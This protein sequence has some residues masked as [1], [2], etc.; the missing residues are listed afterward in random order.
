MIAPS[1]TEE[2]LQL[3]LNNRIRCFLMDF[4]GIKKTEKGFT[5]DMAGK[6]AY[7]FPY[8][9]I[10]WDTLMI[11]GHSEMYYRK[12]SKENNWRSCIEFR[13]PQSGTISVKDYKRYFSLILASVDD[14]PPDMGAYFES[15]PEDL[16]IPIVVPIIDMEHSLVDED[17]EILHFTGKGVIA[18]YGPPNDMGYLST[19]NYAEQIKRAVL[20]ESHRMNR[21]GII[22]LDLGDV[23]SNMFPMMCEVSIE[24][25]FAIDLNMQ[26]DHYWQPIY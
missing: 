4:E 20:E 8:P 7:E 26:E 2:E 15:L 23:Q 25:T 16:I 18:A 17:G 22:S 12:L 10:D 1:N 6:T 24:F 13:R 19:E 21:H 3:N 5:L 14:V 11:S 9:A